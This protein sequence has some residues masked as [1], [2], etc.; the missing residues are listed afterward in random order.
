M[1]NLD[2]F[3]EGCCRLRISHM[4]I[5]FRVI[6]TIVI[7]LLRISKFQERISDKYPIVKEVKGEIQKYQFKKALDYIETEK[8][9]SWEFSNKEKTKRVFIDSDFVFVEYLKYEHFD[10]LFQDVKLI[11]ESLADLYPVKITNRVG[12]RYINQIR[13]GS[14]DPIDWNG[15]IYRA[16][17]QKIS[18][19]HL[20]CGG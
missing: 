12:L 17:S 8:K 5:V 2:S 11:F 16:S 1:Q 6:K 20:S 7:F 14:G 3:E 15:L 18:H 13:I 19:G 10:D 9:F 4:R